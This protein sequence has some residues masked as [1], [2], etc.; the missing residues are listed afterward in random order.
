MVSELAVFWYYKDA[1]YGPEAFVES[2]HATQ[3]GDYLQLNT[4]HFQIWD[5]YRVS[6]RLPCS[7]EYD[8]VPRGRILFYIPTHT[9][10]VIGSKAITQQDDVKHKLVEW[11][12]LP[13]NTEFRWDEHYQ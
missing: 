6:M 10:I 7:V 8:T 1:F 9:F 3:Y 12:G 2:K 5:T 11:Y 13:A 4:D